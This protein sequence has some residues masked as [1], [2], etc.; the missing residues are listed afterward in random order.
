MVVFCCH[1]FV[2]D[3]FTGVSLSSLRCSCGSSSAVGASATSGERNDFEQ[4]LELWHSSSSISF[5]WE[6][7]IEI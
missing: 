6:R 7:P 2:G 1:V 5:H 4:P 3:L